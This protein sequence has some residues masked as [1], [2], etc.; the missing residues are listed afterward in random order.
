MKFKG[1][2]FEKLLFLGIILISLFS[3]LPIFTNPNFILGDDMPFILQNSYIQNLSFQNIIYFFSHSI[4]GYHPLSMLLFSIQWK[5]AGNNPLFYHIVNFIVHII[6]VCLIWLFCK[7]IFKSNIT[8]F[9]VILLFI[10]NP[11]HVQTVS[12]ISELRG[13]LMT[14]FYL[15]SLLFY[16]KYIG[17]NRLKYLLL[18]LL[19]FTF[20]L[21]SNGRAIPL[22]LTLII[23]DIY[24]QKK[25]WSK[26]S[27]LEKLPFFILSLIFGII[28]IYAQKQTGYAYKMSE[29]SGFDYIIIT[30]YSF[31]QYII[32]LIIPVNLTWGYPYP[33]KVGEFL[34][35][36]YYI[37]FSFSLAIIFLMTFSR[38]ISSEIKF[39]FFFYFVNIF[40]LLRLISPL[41]ENIMEDHYSYLPSIGVFFIIASFLSKFFFRFKIKTL[42][43]TLIVSLIF[44]S[45]SYQT[46]E[47]NTIWQDSMTLLTDVINKNPNRFV[48]RNNRG[49]IY[50]KEGKFD[51]AI[52]DFKIAIKIKPDYADPLYGIA[53]AYSE[54]GM[55][56]SSFLYYSKY[57]RLQKIAFMDST[58]LSAAYN[59]R[60]VIYAHNRLYHEAINDFS[61][62]IKINPNNSDPYVGI[63]LS[64]A[65]LNQFEK[66]VDILNKAYLKFPNDSN[67]IST[68]EMI[69]SDKKK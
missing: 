4:E 20:S 52:E 39:G 57:I 21:L 60:G 55:Q 31:I 68:M 29:F 16:I 62:A 8:S 14:N 51:Y 12:Q 53:R 5:I 26:K 3:Y 67:V 61:N 28:N 10:N 58:Q 37:Y 19:F 63:A 17:N 2:Y 22:S 66:A 23:I 47:R 7:K 46:Y 24:F 11:V 48:A 45:F 34:P 18:A 30:G 9:F 1:F 65:I 42:Y 59:N 50:L 69:N 36:Y 64:F 27:I 43:S 54:N 15:F 49:F 32:N 25:Y 13:L 38:K 6:N 44:L 35:L 56:D 40:L 33:F 41:T